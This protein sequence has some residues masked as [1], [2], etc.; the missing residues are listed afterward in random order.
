MYHCHIHFYLAGQPD[1]VFEIIKKI[2][3]FDHFIHEFSGSDRL[4]A[5]LAGEAD[6][7]LANLRDLDV[8]EAMQELISG[9]RKEA[10]LIVLAGSEQMTMLEES[11]GEIRDVW[12]LPMSDAEVEFRFRR[13]LEAFKMSKDFWQT[14]H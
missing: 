9:K 10:E 14:S 12:L 1:G 3:P 2:A 6:V 5:K 8:K 11:L 7:I 4:S 13:W